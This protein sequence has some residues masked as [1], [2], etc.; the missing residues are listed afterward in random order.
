[1]RQLLLRVPDELHKRLT[2][3]AQREGRSVNAIATEMF[4]TSE[5]AVSGSARDVVR[6][7]AAARGLLRTT[8]GDSGDALSHTAVLRKFKRVTLTADELID[9]QRGTR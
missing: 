3:R 2:A 7:R 5:A 1:M 6:A 9:E 4:D 8:G